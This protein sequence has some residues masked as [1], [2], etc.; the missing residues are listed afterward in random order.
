MAVEAPF[1]SDPSVELDGD[2]ADSSEVEVTEGEST[3]LGSGIGLTDFAELLSLQESFQ[4][5]HLRFS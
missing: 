2:A 1:G 5:F 4:K 3:A